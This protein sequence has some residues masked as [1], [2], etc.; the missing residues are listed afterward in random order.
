[1]PPYS[2]E[3]SAFKPPKK[4]KETKAIKPIPKMS[5][6]KKA[7][8]EDRKTWTIEQFKKASK[9]GKKDAKLRIEKPK[10]TLI[11]ELKKDLDVIYSCVVRMEGVDV[12]GYGNCVSCN[13]LQHWSKLQNGHFI[14][15][16]IAPAII[17]ERINTHPQCVRC[18]VL[19]EGNR[20]P[21]S[22]FMEQKYGKDKIALLEHL[23]QRKSNMGAFEYQIMIQEYIELFL[24][25]CARLNHTPTKIQQKIVDKWETNQ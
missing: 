7:E 6:K 5:E 25:Q 23:G 13:T 3:K 18:N 4:E 15:R 8:Q 19:L 2:K 1:M 12:C 11:S 16:S 14:K 10:K 22:R 9:E 20:L 21:Y 24:I 17:F